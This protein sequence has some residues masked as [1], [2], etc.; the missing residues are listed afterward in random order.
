MMNIKD[1]ILSSSARVQQMDVPDWGQVYIRQWTVAERSKFQSAYAEAHK[2][3]KGAD[4]LSN[5][6]A[7]SLSDE[8]GNRLFT[9]D[10]IPLLANRSAVALDDIALAAFEFNG[11]DL[12]AK[13]KN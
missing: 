4:V 5:L 6:V 7:I 1:K 12:D 11:I 8:N 2:E 10:E 13:K 3:G 9:D